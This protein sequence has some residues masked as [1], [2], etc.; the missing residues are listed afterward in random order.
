MTEVLAGTHRQ[1]VSIKPV[2][3][4]SVL[5]AATQSSRAHEGSFFILCQYWTEGSILYPSPSLGG[6]R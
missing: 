4:A 3:A 6:S 2:F 1:V 5:W